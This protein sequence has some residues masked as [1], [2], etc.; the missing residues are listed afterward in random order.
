VAFVPGVEL[1]ARF[2]TEVVGPA[3]GTVA[4]SAGL[5]GWGSDVL[6][7]DT[8]RS[9]DHGW[10]P[11]LVVL[12]QDDA[13]DRARAA[14]EAALPDGFGGWPVRYTAG[15]N[16]PTHHVVVTTVRT[17]LVGHQLG[18]DPRPGLEPVDWLVMPQQR[19]LG[20]VGGA[21]YHDGLGELGPVREQLAGFP[22]DVTAWLVACQ[23]QR[24]VQEHAFVGRAVEV[25]DELGARLV[26]GRLVRELMRLA[27]LYAHRYWPY[28][29]WF[30][31]A[32]A[33]LPQGDGLADVL[34][35]VIAAEDQPAREAAL[36]AACEL[37]A[38]RH[39]AH[40]G[41]DPA[42]IT[43]GPFYER[44]YRV[45]AIEPFIESARRAIA[46]PWL[47]ALPLVGSIDQFVDGTDVASHPSRCAGLRDWYRAL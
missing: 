27:F 42:P 45:L 38:A 12:V 32:F 30:G 34:G 26:A 39:N 20:V 43:V 9:T 5:L 16:P 35:R 17:W 4:H 8:E 21:V 13:V 37:V 18:L 11:R 14:V 7:F 31:T 24:I 23:W 25:G 22:P 3:L 29:K 36:V 44:P 1:N 2:Y 19:L 33:R 46:D 41:W 40:G 28:A 10:G 47:R 6:G 15:R